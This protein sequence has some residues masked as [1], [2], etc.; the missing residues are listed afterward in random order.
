LIASLVSSS[1]YIVITSFKASGLPTVVINMT[2]VY[3]LLKA[4]TTSSLFVWGPGW[5]NELGSWIT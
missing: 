3:Y 5:L 1:K 4:A 2:V